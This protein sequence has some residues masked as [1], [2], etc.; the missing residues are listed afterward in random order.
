ML[1]ARENAFYVV[2]WLHPSAKPLFMRVLTV[3]TNFFYVVTL[4]LQW[5]HLL[6]QQR[7]LGS[8]ITK[9]SDKLLK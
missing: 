1:Y 6:K 9:N 2:T 3:T 8:K 7:S 4:W 5:L